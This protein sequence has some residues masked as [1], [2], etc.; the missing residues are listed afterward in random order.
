MRHSYT[1]KFQ[2]LVAVMLALTILFS[3]AACGKDEEPA[4]EPT[5]AVSVTEPIPEVT[6][7]PTEPPAPAIE[8]TMGTVTTG[9]LNIRKDAGSEHEAVGSYVQYERIE[10][11]ET[12]TVGDTV[13]GRTNKGWIGMGYVRMDGTPF[14]PANNITTDGSFK[15]LGY[16]VV[17]LGSL[18]VR[19]GPGTE[20]SKVREIAQ[21]ARY[22]YYQVQNN[23]VRIEDGWVSTDYFYLEGSKADDGMTAKVISDDLN[24]RTGPSTEYRSVGTYSKD[25]VVQ[26]LA[27]VHNWGYTAKGWISMH[28]VEKTIPNFSTGSGTVASGLN[29]RK[30]A[31][32][33]SELVGTY[34]EGDRVTILEV[35]GTWGRTEKGWINL[36]FVNFD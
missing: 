6:E 10:I 12:K 14:T 32:A 23:W 25:E 29:I 18:N 13:W 5:E 21:N 17:D 3:L 35:Q 24:I 9:K 36:Q 26:I 16:G 11:L 28:H 19:T 4:T 2:T 20:Y 34:K 22:A 27:Q 15:I 33:E 31:N 7:A 8:A 30:E 1:S